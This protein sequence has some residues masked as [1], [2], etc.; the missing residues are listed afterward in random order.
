[1]TIYHNLLELTDEDLLILAEIVRKESNKDK[2]WNLFSQSDICKKIG[3]DYKIQKSDFLCSGGIEAVTREFLKDYKSDYKSHINLLRKAFSSKVEGIEKA[4]PSL[5]KKSK[6]IFL[7]LTVIVI[8][9]GAITINHFLNIHELKTEILNKTLHIS[10]KSSIEEIENSLEYV[11]SF[12]TKYNHDELLLQKN[13]LLKI[14]KS[15][16]NSKFN[17][18]RERDIYNKVSSLPYE[19][20]KANMIGY[21]KLYKLDPQNV[22]Y[23]QKYD[24]YKKLYIEEKIYL[25][26]MRHIPDNY[27]YCDRSYSETSRSVTSTSTESSYLHYNIVTGKVSV[28]P[29][30]VNEYKNTIT[31]SM[32]ED[33]FYK[34]CATGARSN[35][36][37]A[38]CP[39]F[40]ECVSEIFHKKNR[41]KGIPEILSF[42]RVAKILRDDNIERGRLEPSISVARGMHAY[43]KPNLWL[44]DVKNFKNA[45]D[46]VS[47]TYS[48]SV[49]A[50][51]IYKHVPEVPDFLTAQ[52]L[53]EKAVEGYG[54]CNCVLENYTGIKQVMS[55][56]YCVGDAYFDY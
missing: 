32:D 33:V 11:D 28:K 17:S 8:A 2:R 4:N 25:E 56:G 42:E 35:P 48:G 38:A 55:I 50:A 51:E 30:K 18:P 52:K 45:C 16:S 46:V 1:M 10:S 27:Y 24:Q 31:S 47:S 15:K 36:R 29:G 53:G 9:I 3:K 13:N 21:E 5:K 22:N 14:W 34:F 20:F 7:L 23:S 37:T 39:Y 43:N 49:V 12:L 54:E 19:S 26:K 44:Y 40:M 6:R 41:L